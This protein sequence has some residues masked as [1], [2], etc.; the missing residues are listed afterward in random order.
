[1]IAPASALSQAPVQGAV[2]L[3][4]LREAVSAGPQGPQLPEGCTRFAVSVDGTETDAEIEAISKV[5]EACA[6]TH[7]THG[8]THTHTHK[9]P[10]DTSAH[11][12]LCDSSVR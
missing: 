1:M 4:P 2:A 7:H 3:Y 5:C 8:H 12:S 9:Y 6:H 10:P 11:L